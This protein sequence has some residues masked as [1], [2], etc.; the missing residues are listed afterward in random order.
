MASL[1]GCKLF[2]TS[3]RQDAIRAAVSNP[4]NSELVQ[5]LE[6]YLG[7][8]YTSSNIG[9]DHLPDNDSGE[10]DVDD[11]SDGSV[12]EVHTEHSLH[13][14]NGSIPE[15]KDFGE[16]PKLDGESVDD[17]DSTN[18]E[19]S[20]D[21]NTPDS[22]ESASI[23]SASM[24]DD[25][26]ASTVKSVLNDSPTSSGVV[27]TTLKSNEVWVYY[28]DLINLN[29]IMSDVIDTLHETGLH[30]LAFNRLARTDNAIVFTTG[31]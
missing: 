21:D 8:K 4:V 15:S 5:Q 29:K 17:E 23:I 10:V 30:H 12:H 16:N 1:F 25:E 7:D 27:R 20:E 2:V 19:L 18:D 13:S 24:V 28:S 31:D 14:Q 9:L 22:V 26:L 11:E 3:P 6:E